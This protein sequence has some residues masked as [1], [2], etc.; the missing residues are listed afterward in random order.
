MATSTMAADASAGARAAEI[1]AAFLAGAEDTASNGAVGIGADGA[2]G[3]G[4]TF[5]DGAAGGRGDAYSGRADGGA[6]PSD[7]AILGIE[8]GLGGPSNRDVI[9]S[10]ARQNMAGSEESVAAGRR[11]A[12]QNRGIGSADADAAHRSFVARQEN[13]ERRRMT[14]LLKAGRGP[15]EDEQIARGIEA[16][17]VANSDDARGGVGGVA[18][19]AAAPAMPEWLAQLGAKAPSASAE[20][21]ALWQRATQLDAFDR[22]YYGDDAGAQQELVSALYAENPGALRAMFAAA[23]NVLHGSVEGGRVA[24]GLGPADFPRRAAGADLHGASANDV[25][26]S[27]T[28]RSEESMDAARRGAAQSGGL[29]SA[30]AN[31]AHRSFVAR[32]DQ[33]APQDDNQIMRGAAGAEE[34]GGQRP[35]VQGPALHNRPRMGNAEE[36]GQAN[37]NAQGASQHANADA[38]GAAQF[39]AGAYAQFERATNDAVVSDVTRAI[40]RA[41]DHALPAGIADGARRRIAG[42]TLS[43]VHAALRGDRQLS[44]QVSKALRT[45]RFDDA[46]REQVS[47]LIASRARGVVPAAAK[48]VIGEWT[49][50]VLATHRERAAKQQSTQSRVDI[51][52]GGLP[53]PVPRRTVRPSDVDYRATS[54]EEILSW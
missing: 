38:Q 29:G 41:L 36:I 43:E 37:A 1:E 50:S 53:Q 54:D 28:Q 52:G 7:E 42:D 19:G 34:S 15:Q 45:G 16:D 5:G 27:G 9:L 2:S 6:Y 49:G 8:D 32:Q 20:L 35:Q 46:A 39:D 26:L 22:A 18:D 12:A 33:R 17:G 23:A 51:T 25:I 13:G 24:Q 47:R 3:E 44:A 11:R 31:V 10:G 30:D 4:G 21:G 48:R 40:E 14:T